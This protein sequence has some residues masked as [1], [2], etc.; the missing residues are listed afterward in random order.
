MENENKTIDF[1]VQIRTLMERKR[2]KGQKITIAK[3]ARLPDVDLNAN[4][5]YLY[6]RGESEMISSNIEKVL[7][8][9]NA[10]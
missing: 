6:L 1:R 7:N 4:T 10:L 3:L 9:L 5:L 8:A 2:Y